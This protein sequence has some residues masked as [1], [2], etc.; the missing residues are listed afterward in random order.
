MR[1]RRRGRPGNGAARWSPGIARTGPWQIPTLHLTADQAARPELIGSW[2]GFHRPGLLLWD[3]RKSPTGVEWLVASVPLPAGSYSYGIVVGGQLVTDDQ[4]PQTTFIRD[5]LGA[6]PGP[7]GAEV[8]SAVVPD[9]AQPTLAVGS[10]A[11]SP[12]PAGQAGGTVVVG[13]DFAP[14]QDGAALDQGS[15]APRAELRRGQDVL[16]PP[17]LSVS[18]GAGGAM[19]ISATASG[20]QPGKYQIVVH[21]ADQ[22]GRAVSA[23]ASAFVE[24][25]PAGSGPE[26]RVLQDGIIYHLMIDRF[27][28]NGPL[29]SPPTPGD[30]AGGTLSGVRQM[31]LAGHFQR[32]G[33]TTL[34][35]SPVY[36]NPPGL[37]PG[38][39]GH[40]YQGYH[41]YWPAASRD[42]ETQIGGDPQLDPLI[43]D[44]HAQGIR[45]ILD[46]VPHHVHESHPY[47][48]DHSRRAPAVAQAA[49]PAAASWFLDG[50]EAC[51]CGDPA[52]GW[53][54]HIQVCWFD[55]YLP[56]LN[57]RQPDAAQA[58]VDDL[59]FWMSRFDIDGMRID[60][61]PMMPRASTRRIARATRSTMRRDGLDLL[62][63]G[64]TY[65]GPGDDGRAQIR[66]Y[67]GQQFDGLDSEFDFPLM[68]ALRDIVAHGRGGLDTLEGE[69]AD[70]DRA[71]AGSGRGHRPH[72][73]QPRHH[74][75]RLRGGP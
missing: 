75:L 60:A 68:W 72:R 1:R 39:D 53:G 22:K 43:A 15:S 70:S 37:L 62:M 51:V 58:G 64:E 28:G 16:P 9:C 48:L 2:D 6:A 24:T 14:G 36:V 65:T 40:M 33:V 61:V 59:L 42:V 23:A 26:A 3:H 34:W 10:L 55:T 8:S 11:A 20:L 49:D 27:W 4:N 30:R 44:A 7:Y 13:A 69:I 46:M 73:R 18:A 5:P 29:P 66:S 71:W 47:Y 25:G 67:L 74:P 41:G 35:L 56:T 17:Q 50:P 38:R 52:C 54:D 21:A 57:W 31:L 19:R 63:L 45:V 32:L 12:S